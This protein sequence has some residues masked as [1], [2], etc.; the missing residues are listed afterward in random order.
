M[1]V[2]NQSKKLQYPSSFTKSI[3]IIWKEAKFTATL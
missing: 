1:K 3:R 2:K